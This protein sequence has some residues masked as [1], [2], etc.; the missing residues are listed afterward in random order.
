MS[1]EYN[2][3]ISKKARLLRIA[4]QSD[5]SVV[6]TAPKYF[7]L[8]KIKEFVDKKEKW[9]LEKQKKFSKLEKYN[10][11]KINKK[12]LVYYKNQAKFLVEDRIKY[13]NKFYN[14]KYS[15]ISIKKQKTRWGSCSKLGNLNFNYK[16]VFLP[17]NLA[18]YLVVHEMCHLAELN[19]S[20][21]F[22]NLVA[23][24]IPNYKLLSKRLKNIH[25]I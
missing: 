25:F 14:L 2:L 8:S 20:K 11:P 18:D 17:K 10:L 24:A 1:I 23:K 5:G 7:S 13:F 12:S 6:V 3:K 15:K 16:I 22:W 19:H 21:N 4:V 9:I